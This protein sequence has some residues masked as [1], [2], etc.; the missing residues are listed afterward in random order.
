[1]T[2]YAVLLLSLFF[3]FPSYATKIIGNGGD[4]YALEFVEYAGFIHRHIEH[5]SM[6]NL[7]PAQFI[8]AVDETKVEST[9]AKLLLNNIPKDAINYPSARRIIFN[10][11]RWSSMSEAE[12]AT[13]VFHE[14]LGI[15]GIDDSRYQI[16]KSLLEDFRQDRLEIVKSE[17]VIVNFATRKSYRVNIRMVLESRGPDENTYNANSKKNTLLLEHD[18][19]RVRFELPLNG[20]I[21]SLRNDAGIE[22]AGLYIKVLVPYRQ[23]NDTEEE[24][25]Q[26]GSI[27][28]KHIVVECRVVLKS[29]KKTGLPETIEFIYPISN[30]AG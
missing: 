23:E 11:I 10:R 3:A 1:M 14:Y 25:E 19:N 22:D 5:K 28:I 4:V 17:E 12:R 18:G 9:D 7:N 27:Y 21:L 26:E 2:S 29:S 16:S 8:K 30:T 24:I 15:M 13:L 20:Q 6:R